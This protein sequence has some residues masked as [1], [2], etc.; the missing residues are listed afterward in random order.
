MF[1]PL[2]I[3]ILAASLFASPIAFS[4]D[5]TSVNISA[6]WEINSYDPAVSGF[7]FHRLQVM[8][9][10]VDADTKGILIS[11]LATEWSATEDGMSWSFTVREGVK[12][13]NGTSRR[14]VRPTVKLSFNSWLSLRSTLPS[15]IK[16]VLM[17]SCFCL[18]LAANFW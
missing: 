12:F 7:A 8:E 4:A 6:P 14:M 2:S 9:T 1:K 15:H 10:L 16:L 5:K 3:A 18:S 17:K 13:H 11:G